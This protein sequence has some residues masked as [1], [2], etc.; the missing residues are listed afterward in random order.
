MKPILQILFFYFFFLTCFI[1]V[2][3]QPYPVRVQVQLIPPYPANISDYKNRAV[4]SFTNTSQTAADVYLRGSLKN[5]RGQFIQTKPNIFSNS[6]IHIPGLQT[7]VVQGNQFDGNFLDLNNLQT[8][9][10]QQAYSNLFQSGM[11]PEGYYSF[12]IYAYSRNANGNYVPVSDPQAAGTCFNYNLGYVV[13]PRILS[14]MQDAAITATTNQN[15]NITWTRP[16]GN[17]QNAS[18]V[19]DLFLV[20]VLPDEDPNVTLTNAVQYGSGIFFKQQNIQINN[21]PFTN[22]TSFQ[23]DAG[24]KYAIMVQ[25]RDLTGKTAFE[26]NGRSEMAAFTYGASAPP[27]LIMPAPIAGIGSPSVLSGNFTCSCKIPI[28]TLDK[29][30]NNASLKNGGSFTMA[31]LTINMGTVTSSGSTVSGTGTVMVS[32]VPVMISFK[33][34]IVNKDGVAIA[35]T[36]SGSVSPGFDFLNNGGT[37]AVSTANY[38]SFIDQITKYNIAAVKNGAGIPLPFGLNQIGAPDAVNIGVIGLSISPQQAAYDAIAAV[39]L[40]D[41]NNV[42]SL[43]AKNVCFSSASPMCGDAL[44]VLNQDFQVPAINLNFKGYV[45]DAAPGTFVVL[46][47]SQI[48]HCLLYTSD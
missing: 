4:I 23:L 17:L 37:P 39:K 11:I 22:L 47:N 1:R 9:L 6:P 19:Y 2:N 28:S 8:N 30:N 3:G 5:D 42:L 24:S 45:S 14:P 44:F 43:L 25:A 38:Q 46:S 29:T 7:V 10:D 13:P 32:G 48:K 18:L 34:V 21:F 35:G 16:A 33:D 31:S 26:N 12:C 15:I 41:A 40:I 36:A 27:A 20:K